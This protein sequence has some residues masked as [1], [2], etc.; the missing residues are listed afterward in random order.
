MVRPC[1]LNL[2]ILKQF[3]KIYITKNNYEKTT[4]NIPHIMLACIDT[5]IRKKSG[6]ESSL[7]VHL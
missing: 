3:I 2:L 5:F 1:F 4:H 7:H 6:S